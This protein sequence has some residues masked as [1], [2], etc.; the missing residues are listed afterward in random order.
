MSRWRRLSV[1]PLGTDVLSEF[2]NEE[3]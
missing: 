3:S 1:R 2:E